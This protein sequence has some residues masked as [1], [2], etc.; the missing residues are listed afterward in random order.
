[1]LGFIILAY[2]LVGLV[3][4]VGGVIGLMQDRENGNPTLQGDVFYPT[5][6]WI[7]LLSCIAWPHL[8]FVTLWDHWRSLKRLEG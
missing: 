1:M 4:G 7:V 6:K 3:L 2:M 5:L 8:L